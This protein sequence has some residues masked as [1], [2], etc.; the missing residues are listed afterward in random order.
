MVTSKARRLLRVTLLAI[1]SVVMVAVTLWGLGAIW[2][3]AAS[4]APLGLTLV[5]AMLAALWAVWAGAGWPRYLAL[6]PFAAALLGLGLWWTGLRP[7]ADRD[8]SPQ[9]A[10]LPTVERDGDTLVF[11]NVRDFRWIQAA[12]GVGLGSGEAIAAE[13]WQTR[14]IRPADVAGVDL[15]FSYWAGPDIAHMIVSFPLDDAPPLALSIE[16]RRE[17][18]EAYAPLAGFFKSYELAIVAAEET[19]I[20]ALRTHVWREDV[21]LYRLAVGRDTARALLEAYVRE[22]N[23]LAAAPRWYH[24]IWANCTTVAFGLAREVWPGLR[25]DWRVLL[26]GH[27]PAYAYEIGA[28]VPGLSLEELTEKAAISARARSLTVDERFPFAIRE[29]VPQAQASPRRP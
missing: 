3:R 12:D 16:I 18:G 11:R 25:L 10:R 14:R 23:A 24:T 1:A 15:F 28:L 6:A 26:P 27:A 8:W 22:I 7:A 21:R 13:R 9:L 29:G 4:P 19:D 5:A 2:F 20:V 17:R